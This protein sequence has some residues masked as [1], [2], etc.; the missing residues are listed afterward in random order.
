MIN[1][2]AQ[3][4]IGIDCNMHMGKVIG[5]VVSTQKDDSLVG[6]KLMIVQE[7]N[8]D[9]QDGLR[10]EVAADTVGAGI[11]EYVLYV[12]GAGARHSQPGDPHTDVMD[13]A[14]VGIIDRFDK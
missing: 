8:S 12:R 9:L 11:G 7:I 3:L 2:V 4:K 14:I 13:A 6:R 10:Q 5:S 1:R